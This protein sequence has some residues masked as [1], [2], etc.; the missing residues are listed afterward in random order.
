MNLLSNTFL[1]NWILIPCGIIALLSTSYSQSSDTKP[2]QDIIVFKIKPE[3]REVCKRNSI[4]SEN[5]NAIMDQ[6]NPVY[7]KKMFP[8]HK[9]PVPTKNRWGNKHLVDLSL[10]YEL[11]LNPSINTQ[12]AIALLKSSDDIAYAQPKPIAYPLF[13]PNDDSI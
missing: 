1:L 8:H 3:C 12:K 4:E 9:A 11:Q 6:I 10:I 5:L 2:I 13:I 7:L